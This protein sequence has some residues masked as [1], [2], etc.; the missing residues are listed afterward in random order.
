M[1]EDL[2]L[3]IT[4]WRMSCLDLAI[5][6][7]RYEGLARE[8]RLCVFCDAVE[9]EKHAI[10]D[11]RAYC[12]IRNN[13]KKMLEENSSVTLILNPK[14]T[15]MANSVGMYLKLLEEERKSLI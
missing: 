1:R 6:T 10:F 5:E 4:R 7:G 2:R 3:I 12:T 15:E 11:C 14:S 13:Y 9:D 8:D